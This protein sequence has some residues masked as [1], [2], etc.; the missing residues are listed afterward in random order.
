MATTDL[1]IVRHPETDANV[2]GRF[3]GQGESPF[4]AEGRKQARR[5]PHKIARFR[6]QLIWTSPLQRA[7]VV[8]R[9]AAILAGVELRVDKRLL[10]LDFGQAHALTWEEIAE[11]GIPF[12]YRA[13]DE[14]VAPGGES[15]NQL[16][17]RV[18]SAVE[19]AVAM[20]GRHALVCHA[21]VM[22]AVLAHTLHLSGDQLWMFAIH[23][24]QLTQV[25]VID[26]HAQL[27]EFVQG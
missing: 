23:N 24:A 21:G 3:V 16:E 11:A 17:A 6:P 15:R 22:R 20:G 5:L 25:R 2:N 27:V 10:E 18:G 8:A 4:T 1:L 7:L 14:P 13:A 12:N 9:R 19:D 26:G